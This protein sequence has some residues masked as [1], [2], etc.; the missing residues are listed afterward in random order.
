MQIIEAFSASKINNHALNED[1]IFYNDAYVAV[2][3]GVTNKASHSIWRPSPGVFTKNVLLDALR[4]MPSTFTA[5]NAY[6]YLNQVLAKQ[7]PNLNYFTKNAKQR[8]Q[9]NAIIYSAYHQEV[10][11]MGDCHCLIDNTYHQNVKKIDNLLSEVRS[12]VFAADTIDNTITRDNDIGRN[13]IWPFL[14][15]EANLANTD[16]EFGY[17]V[18]DGLGN[19]PDKIKVLDATH[20]HSIILASDGYPILKDSLVQTEATLSELKNTD[21]LL[22]HTYKSTKGFNS[23]QQS[24]DDRTYLK[25]E[26]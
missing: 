26:I 22:I 13:A 14:Q 18:L 5:T 16:N 17:L 2:I 8:L 11:F 12:F 23:K 21:P 7:Y 3:D 24:F 9:A 1:G 15:L 6:H 25:F 20:A 19:C 10:W 4:T